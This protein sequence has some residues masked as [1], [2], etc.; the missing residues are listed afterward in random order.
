[1]GNICY[2]SPGFK[3][4]AKK[5]DLA[6]QNSA[7]ENDK[8][9]DRV[10]FYTYNP[11]WSK[12]ESTL[13]NAFPNNGL[14]ISKIDW[15]TTY[16]SNCDLKVQNTIF[17]GY[18]SPNEPKGN[19]EL[20]PFEPVVF[21]NKS[22]LGM[23]TDFNELAPTDHILPAIILKYA[24]DKATSET[25]TDATMATIDAASMITGYGEL[26][27][28]ITGLR[29]AWVIA[30]MVNAGVNLSVNATAY[31]N[32]K[33]KELLG[34]YNM[35]TGAVALGR[36]GTGAVKSVRNI[37]KALKAESGVMGKVSITALL[38][39]IK[40]NSADLGQLHPDDAANMRAYLQRL[41]AEANAR[42]LTNLEKSVD[43][44]LELMKRATKTG[45]LLVKRI[46]I[47]KFAT[48]EISIENVQRIHGVPKKGTPLGNIENLANDFKTNGYNLE[49]GPPIEGYAMPDGK[50]LIIDG[51]HRLAALEQ[52]GET[53]IPIRI[54]K[55][56]TPESLRL[57]LKIGEY[58]GFYPPLKYPTGFKVPDLGK[59]AN[60]SID[61]DA[62][63]FV[64]TMFE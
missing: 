52:I 51:H 43:E 6:Y 36:M 8:I 60:M 30:D 35:A 61:A 28:G 37:Y 15:S 55:E 9:P 48:V 17:L 62:L 1:L 56:M 64:S 27:L 12:I 7:G 44:A 41:K 53:S 59:E 50:I 21:E 49:I 45:E 2:K 47:N 38:K 13:F 18:Q 42:Q 3:D 20:N 31:D 32:P 14:D 11:F 25:A 46:G 5:L 22:D 24:E 58:S 54:Q 4:K 16:L 19:I 10:I 33:I 26:K 39:S 57:N 34:Y 40:E 23:L 29:K 63:R